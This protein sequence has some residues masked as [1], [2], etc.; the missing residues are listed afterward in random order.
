MPTRAERQLRR[1]RERVAR[2]RQAL[3]DDIKAAADRHGATLGSVYALVV[4]ELGIGDAPQSP[5]PP[6]FAGWEGFEQ[7]AWVDDRGIGLGLA[8]DG[9]RTLRLTVATVRSRPCTHCGEA[10]PA[11][12]TFRAGVDVVGQLCDA[13]GAALREPAGEEQ[14]D[15]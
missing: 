6:Q 7:A 8:M 5:A 4:S 12:Y 13:M 11:G 9:S 15:D 1:S 2:A 14:D 3:L 10:G